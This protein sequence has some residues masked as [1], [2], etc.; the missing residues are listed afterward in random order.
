MA[1]ARKLDSGSWRALVYSHTESVLQ[2]DG[3]I[4]KVRRYESFTADTEAEANLMAAQFKV[5]R[6]RKSRPANLTVMEAMQQYVASKNK[7][8]SP[9]TLRGYESII[10]NSLPDIIDL[11]LKELTYP[12]IQNAFN[13]EAFRKSPKTVRNIHGLF[14]AAL[15]TYLP[16]FKLVTTMPQRKKPKIHVPTEEEIKILINSLAGTN[17]EIPVL[18]AAFGS[19]RRSE[20]CALEDTDIKGDIIDINKA[21][22]KKSNNHKIEWVLKQPKTFTSYRQVEMPHFVIEK[23]SGI[24]G[25]IVTITPDYLSEKFRQK[26][27]KMNIEKFRFHDLRHYQASILHALGIPDKYIMERGGWKTDATLKNVYQHT[28]ADKSKQ[29]TDRANEHFSSIYAT[30]NATQNK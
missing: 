20:I 17:L 24:K 22:V 30:R 15:N 10:R 16:S 11:P 13:V 9:S 19:M 18:L 4:K 21:L 28:I 1:N 2:A 5:E 6:N 25:R 7:I 8:L 27:A 29:F 12:I 23:L 3:T 14:S 26:L